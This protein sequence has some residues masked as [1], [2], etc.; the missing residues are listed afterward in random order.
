MSVS[1]RPLSPHLSAY[2]WRITM[3]SSI[4]HRFSGVALAFGAVLFVSTLLMLAGDP[5][6]FAALARLIGSW[7]GQVVLIG[8]TLAVFYHLANGIRHLA[9]DAGYGFEKSTATS[10]AWF[11]V[12]ASIVATALFWTA[13]YLA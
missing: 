4:L 6:D 5:A 11:V 12:S 2:G 10:T 9:W 13:I 7:P 1:S 8:L 3:L